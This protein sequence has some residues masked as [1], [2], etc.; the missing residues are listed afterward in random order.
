VKGC[1]L[2][3]IWFEKGTKNLQHTRQDYWRMLVNINSF[4]GLGHEI[5]FKCLDRN[6]QFLEKK[7][8]SWFS[9]FQNVPLIGCRHYHFSR[10]LGENIWVI[11]T[12]IRDIST[13]FFCSPHCLLLVH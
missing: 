4:T 7:N 2:Y 12:L 8:L 3:F 10:G 11:I 13:E 6:E 1:G 5:E 9:N